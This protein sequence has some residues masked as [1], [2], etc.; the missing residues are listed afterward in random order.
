MVLS[1]SSLSM[2]ECVAGS[3]GGQP[4]KKMAYLNMGAMPF[5]W[6]RFCSCSSSVAATVAPS[7]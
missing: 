7:E 3:T 2:M 5:S 4:A 1:V 6:K